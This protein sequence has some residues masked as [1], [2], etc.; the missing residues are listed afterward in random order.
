MTSI[1]VDR[2]DLLLLAE[3]QK[4][5]NATNSVL[6]E[7][8]HMSTS[9]VSRRVIRLQ[10]AKI[11]DHYSAVIEPD[12]VGLDVTA[13]TEVTLDRQSP[14]ASE[15]FE[16]QVQVLP[17]ILDCY[18][19]AGQADYL[20]RIVA[21]DLGAF[22]DFMAKH[23]LSMQEIENVKSTI[24]LRKLKRTHVVPLDA[25]MRPTATKRKIHFAE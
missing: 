20:L 23:I 25:V 10:E 6:G 24:T 5:G 16:R 2:F 19:I 18:S 22:S 7:K 14:L 12:A 3:L 8:L 13:F 9:Q 15:K 11:I 4:D 17:Q 21:A 1:A